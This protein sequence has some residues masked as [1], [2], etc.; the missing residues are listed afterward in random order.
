MPFLR[1]NRRS[2]AVPVIEAIY[3]TKLLSNDF[4]VEIFSSDTLN[5][6]FLKNIPQIFKI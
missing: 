2:K 6:T 3:V 1:S 4:S 5:F